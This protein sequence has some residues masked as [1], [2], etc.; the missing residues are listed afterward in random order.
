MGLVG[1]N[2]VRMGDGISKV[3]RKGRITW[4]IV[5]CRQNAG[6]GAMALLLGEFAGG[7]GILVLTY[8]YQRAKREF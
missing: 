7:L 1:D 5:W 4:W 8:G 3:V 6:E 2:R